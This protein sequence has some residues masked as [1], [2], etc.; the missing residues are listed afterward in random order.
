MCHG[1]TTR[2][3]GYVS[4][5][6]SLC[7]QQ[8]SQ[9][10]LNVHKLRV[11]LRGLKNNSRR[12]QSQNCG[13]HPF[14]SAGHAEK[15]PECRAL[16]TAKINPVERRAPTFSA[17]LPCSRSSLPQTVFSRLGHSR[18]ILG[19]G[20][21]PNVRCVLRNHIWWVPNNFGRSRLLL[22]EADGSR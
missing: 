11:Y 2:N 14:F 20:M 10:V 8:T 16:G 5:A 7:S 22:G 6:L 18:Y 4:V 21:E 12:A 19:W 1:G 9:S 15:L 13:V 3:V 17:F